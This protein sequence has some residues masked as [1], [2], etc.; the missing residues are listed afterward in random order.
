MIMIAQEAPSSF[1]TNHSGG[2]HFHSPMS[3]GSSSSPASN[4]PAKADIFCNLVLPTDDFLFCQS[5]EDYLAM[6]KTHLISDYEAKLVVD[7]VTLTIPT[8]SDRELTTASMIMRNI[9]SA[10][11]H[12]LTM[13]KRAHIMKA[14]LTASTIRHFLRE[15][16]QWLSPN[17]IEEMQSFSF[18]QDH[19]ELAIPN[20]Q[21]ALHLVGFIRVLKTLVTVIQDG[22]SNKSL[23]LNVCSLLEGSGKIYTAGGA[24]SKATKRREIILE[25]FMGIATQLTVQGN[26]NHRMA[27]V[28][29]TFNSTESVGKK[30]GRPSNKDST[31]TSRDKQSKASHQSGQ[32]GSN[33]P[34]S[35]HNAGYWSAISSGSSS[36][37]SEADAVD[38]STDSLSDNEESSSLST[39]T[40]LSQQPLSATTTTTDSEDSLFM[41][42]ISSYLPISVEER[43]D[44]SCLNNHTSSNNSNSIIRS[45]PLVSDFMN[46]FDPSFEFMFV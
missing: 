32:D 36:T 5:T 43:T 26:D 28:E 38:L 29:D 46:Y 13:T 37:C 25:R 9:P 4:N 41:S 15:N 10:Y 33:S 16:N 21:E 27:C 22:K 39:N 45:S 20:R 2:I 34:I 19:D 17:A 24:P 44:N 42:I 7:F 1:S 6:L 31:V 23:F 14:I 8:M 35:V 11:R 18:C 3:L 30:R 12:T 40:S